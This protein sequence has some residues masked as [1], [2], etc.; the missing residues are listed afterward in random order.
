M[1]CSKCGSQIKDG[2]QFC[3]K[4]GTPAENFRI[5]SR[6][7]VPAPSV[8][9]I[10]PIMPM[11][12]MNM[13]Q[14][15]RKEKTKNNVKNIMQGKGGLLVVGAAA[16]LLLIAVIVNVRQINHFLHKTFSS[17][18]K[19]YQFVEKRTADAL[20]DTA[21]EWYE[22]RILEARDYSDKGFTLNLTVETGDGFKNLLQVL[23]AVEDED[24]PWLQSVSINGNAAVQ[25]DVITLKAGVNVN[26]N[27][28]LSGN[29]IMDM[30]ESDIYVQLPNLS[31]KYA[32]FDANLQG[33]SGMA[34]SY[35]EWQESGKEA[36]AACPDRKTVEKLIKRYLKV[37]IN[38]LEKDAVKK[39]KEKITVG[40]ITQKLTVLDVTVDGKTG[41]KVIKAVL[42]E[43]KDD[44]DVKKLLLDTY[45]LDHEG[46]DAEGTYEQFRKNIV[47]L[48][49]N[50]D[51][52]EAVVPTMKMTVY[53]DRKGRIKGR[54]ISAG[55]IVIKSMLA[56]KGRNFA[57]EFSCKEKKE[58]IALSGSGVRK[59]DLIEG[60][61]DLR[62]NDISMD[63]S[64][65]SFSVEGIKKGRW[66]GQLS[67]KFDQQ[68]S[69]QEETLDENALL[70]DTFNTIFTPQ[71]DMDFAS[72]KKSCG[73]RINLAAAS[74]EIGELSFRI[75][76]GGG[77]DTAIPSV[78]D[79]ILISGEGLGEWVKSVKLD[80]LI[81]AA[82]G[83]GLPSETIELLDKADWV[84]KNLSSDEINT[85]FAYVM[86]YGD[87][88]LGGW[89]TIRRG[90]FEY[91]Y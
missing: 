13:K 49:E 47:S 48:L 52:L 5:P 54:D 3:P 71:I 53:V 66:N 58:N 56:E 27:D 18:V 46:G 23:N 15:E 31:D 81:A 83:S 67:L 30:G 82:E 28:L 51:D 9:G 21:G 33:G 77:G 22:S 90:L 39:S 76:K 32:V 41:K 60:D 1:F 75:E 65:K 35:H 50:M 10:P 2:I 19:Y 8:Q 73:C 80:K 29:A 74:M 45:A 70:S 12:G 7:T 88:F 79:A 69:M 57:C 6:Q 20:A 11:S 63:I 26:H 89:D 36:L 84:L 14:E 87:N 17:P 44:K 61:F 4:C 38:D 16:L 55:G 85:V 37:A 24:I 64:A 40:E 25:D 86:D 68:D 72:D 42:E 59:G 34:K 91:G 62:G 78:E 43:M